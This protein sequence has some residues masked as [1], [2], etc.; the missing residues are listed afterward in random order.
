MRII[1]TCFGDFEMKGTYAICCGDRD[2]YYHLPRPHWLMTD[3]QIKNFFEELYE[4]E[5]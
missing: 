3:K 2:F 4:F 1:K 5:Q